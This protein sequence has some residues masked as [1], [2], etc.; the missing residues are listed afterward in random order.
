[1]IPLVD[2]L[3]EA[4]LAFS[5]VIILFANH[6]EYAE[7]LYDVDIWNSVGQRAIVFRDGQAYDI[8]WTTPQIDQPIK[9]IDANG[10]VLPLKPG[11]TW[12]AIMGIYSNVAENEGSW[13]FTF[14]VP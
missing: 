10:D 3:T 4:Q 9:F 14:Q 2:R 12:V 6:T 8:T 11:N 5:N 1:M 7:T 13:T